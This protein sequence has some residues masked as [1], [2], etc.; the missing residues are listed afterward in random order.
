[1]YTC[2]HKTQDTYLEKTREDPALSLKIPVG[3]VQ[4]R[5]EA[6]GKGMNGLAK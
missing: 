1:M 2:M 3:S 4:A 6:S 5:S